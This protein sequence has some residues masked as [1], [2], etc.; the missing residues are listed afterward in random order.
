MKRCLYCYEPLEGGERDYHL[1][2]S[3]KFFGTS[4]PPEL[5]YRLEEVNQLATQIVQRSVTITGVQPKLSVDVETY[6]DTRKRSRFTIVG[7]WG[8]YVLKPPTEQYPSLPENEDLTMHL[9]EIFGI[10]IVPH[11][12]IRFSSGELA[13][14]TRRVDRPD[15]IKLAMEDACQLTERLTED[16]YKG[17]MEQVGKVI[18]RFCENRGFDLGEFFKLALFSF[19]TGN[20]DMHLKNFSLLRSADGLVSFAPAYDLL[21]TTLVIPEDK[22]ELALTVNGKKRN[23]RKK[24]FH[25]LSKQ[26]ALS[27]TV[28]NNFLEDFSAALPRAMDFIIKSFLPGTQREEYARV[29]RERASRIDLDSQL[30]RDEHAH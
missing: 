27:D 2:C 22:D 9:A 15:G 30:A 1:R 25:E 7:L 21:S 3:R 17:S 6:K 28:A 16:K 10:R 23:H 8:K 12:L 5:P 29:I 4:V 18:A 11:S 13:Y 20:A 24:D 26:L 19:L 14:I